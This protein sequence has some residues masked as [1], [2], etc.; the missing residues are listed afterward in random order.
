MKKSLVTLLVLL[1]AGFSGFAQKYP[2]GLVDKTVAVVG[3]EVILISDIEDQ[4]QQMT[5][6]GYASDRNMRAWTP[7]P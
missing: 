3:N 2:G 7:S 4:V 6:Q 1:A 5:A